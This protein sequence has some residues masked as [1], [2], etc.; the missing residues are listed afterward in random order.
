MGGVFSNNIIIS[1]IIVDERGRERERKKF[2]PRYIHP[3]RALCCCCVVD[4]DGGG[5]KKEGDRR[6]RT[7]AQQNGCLPEIAEFFPFY[8]G[9]VDVEEVEWGWTWMAVL[10]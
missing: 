1:I 6:N 2:R 5:R 7:L 10:L 3:Q 9:L 4:G 8:V